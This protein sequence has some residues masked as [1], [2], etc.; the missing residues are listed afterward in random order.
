MAISVAAIP[1]STVAAQAAWEIRAPAETRVK[2]LEVTAHDVGAVASSR[3]IGRPAAI[4]VDP[5]SNLLQMQN[6]SDGVSRV[7]YAHVWNTTNPT[8]P[9]IYHRRHNVGTAG[10][11]S[12]IWVFPQGLIIPVSQTIVLINITTTNTTHWNIVV[13]E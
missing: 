10:G 4:G 6:P 9:T 11:Y 12:F 13:D 1:V 5:V 7:T 2:I 3:G 8:A